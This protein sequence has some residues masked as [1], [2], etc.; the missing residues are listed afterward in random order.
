[1]DLRR[2]DDHAAERAR[3]L[4]GGRVRGVVGLVIDARR[5]Q[6]P[7]ARAGGVGR[8]LNGRVLTLVALV[9]ADEQDPPAAGGLR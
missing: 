5:D 2:G 6:D 4:G 9:S 1:V 3:G 8:R 7:V